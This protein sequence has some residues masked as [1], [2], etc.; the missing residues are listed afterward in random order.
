MKCTEVT[1]FNSKSEN[2]KCGGLSNNSR[3]LNSGARL[4][5]LFA[6]HFARNR[7]HKTHV[8]SKISKT[9][10][11]SVNLYSITL[12]QS[13]FN[14]FKMVDL[15]LVCIINTFLR[16]YSVYNCLLLWSRIERPSLKSFPLHSFQLSFFPR[17]KV[18]QGFCCQSLVH[19]VTKRFDWSDADWRL[20][21]LGRN[22]YTIP[23]GVVF[24]I[25]MWF[26]WK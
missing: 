11:E 13:V 1:C 23:C 26:F 20:L 22:L 5:H 15:L 2:G 12:I 14:N 16:C 9:F 4:N 18:T 8:V 10:Y 17:Q 24:F 21:L 25:S 3:S 7:T 19:C 6:S